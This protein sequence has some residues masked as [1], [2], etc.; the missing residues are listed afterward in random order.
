MLYHQFKTVEHLP[1]PPESKYAVNNNRPEGY[2][3]YRVGRLY[4][5]PD[6]I[7]LKKC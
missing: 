3:D 6:D 5:D 1:N 7:I 4:L 2:A